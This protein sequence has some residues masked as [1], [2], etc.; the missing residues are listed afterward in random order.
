MSFAIYVYN[1]LLQSGNNAVHAVA[2]FTAYGNCLAC[3]SICFSLAVELMLHASYYHRHIVGAFW[4]DLNLAKTVKYVNSP[5][6]LS[7]TQVPFLFA[8]VHVFIIAW[9]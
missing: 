4:H 6:K 8:V 1:V 2:N 9:T 5:F 3:A 7:S